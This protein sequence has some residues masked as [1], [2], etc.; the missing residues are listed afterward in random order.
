MEDLLRDKEELLLTGDGAS[1]LF[2]AEVTER[3]DSNN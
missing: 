1:P 2:A 3:F